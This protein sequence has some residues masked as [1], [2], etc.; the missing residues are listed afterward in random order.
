MENL[1]NYTPEQLALIIC[2]ILQ[3]NNYYEPINKDYQL[4]FKVTSNEYKIRVNYNWFKGFI[5]GTNGNPEFA[6]DNEYVSEA[7]H[8][9]VFKSDNLKKFTKEVIDAI[10]EVTASQFD[11]EMSKDF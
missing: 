9:D 4:E 3:C 7:N 5:P 1:M 10:N 8:F 2:G 6:R 11:P